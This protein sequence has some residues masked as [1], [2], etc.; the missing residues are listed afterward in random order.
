MRQH[1][2]QTILFLQGSVK[3]RKGCCG[4]YM[5]CFVGNLFRCKSA[6]N[7]KIWLRFYKAISIEHQANWNVH[8]FGPPCMCVTQSLQVGCVRRRWR[9]VTWISVKMEAHVVVLSTEVFTAHAQSD[10]AARTAACWC[11]DTMYVRRFVVRL[12][13][14]EILS[15]LGHMPQKILWARKVLKLIHCTVLSCVFFLCV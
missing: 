13:L 4:Q 14:L 7:Y 3:T 10:M 8:V 1:R 2:K 12:D 15:Y 6:K 5:H 11:V 9:F